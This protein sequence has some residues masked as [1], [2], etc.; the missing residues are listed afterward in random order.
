MPKRLLAPQASSRAGAEKLSHSCINLN[1]KR[2]NIA[3]TK[4][5]MRLKSNRGAFPSPFTVVYPFLAPRIGP[6]LL[7]VLRRFHTF[8]T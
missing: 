2:L 3:N 6:L 8:D 5:K 7:T 1:L 4:Q